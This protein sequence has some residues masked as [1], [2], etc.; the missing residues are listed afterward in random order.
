MKNEE[1]YHPTWEIHDSS[2]IQSFMD[3]PRRF[4]FDYILGWQSEVANH[5]LIFGQAFHDAMEVIMTNPMTEDVIEP[6]YN[7][8]LETYRKTYPEETDEIYEPKSPKNAFYGLAAYIGQYRNQDFFTTLYTEVG[9]KVSTG[10]HQVVYK[11]DTIC[12]DHNERVFSFE[13][14]TT[15]NGFK[16]VWMDEWLLSMQIG[17]YSYAMRCLY[18]NVSTPLVII[19]GVAFSKKKVDC[20]R[21]PVKKTPQQ[22]QNWLFTVNYWVDQIKNEIN[23]LLNDCSVDDQILTAFPMNPRACTNYFRLCPFHDF[24]MSWSN[25]LR[26]A[27]EG[28]PEGFVTKRWDPLEE[29][30][31]KNRVDLEQT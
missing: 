17:C 15:K 3:C 27:F 23:V 10:K 14:K 11:L 4:F 24:C 16:Q 13:H 28:P 19:N 2:K 18:P 20:Q 25:P 7:A 6:A 1:L 8:F 22:L 12:Q 21:Q 31:I 9:G 26:Q 5:D 29:L 30:P